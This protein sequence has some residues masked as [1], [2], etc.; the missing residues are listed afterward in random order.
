MP[1]PSDSLFRFLLYY[2]KTFGG[3]FL[4][5][6][7]STFPAGLPGSGLFLLRAMLGIT[8]IVQGKY[9]AEQSDSSVWTFFLGISA[10]VGGVLLLIGFLTPVIGVLLFTV[11]LIAAIFLISDSSQILIYEII[12]SASVVLLGPGAFSI[13]A[14]LFGRREIIILKN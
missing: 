4:Q 12:L 1:S 13:D 6:L 9:L 5:R 2:L 14:K 7:F 10:I 8:A 11:N 3:D